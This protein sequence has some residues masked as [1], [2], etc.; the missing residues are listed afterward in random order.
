MYWFVCE[1]RLY[2]GQQWRSCMCKQ[3]YVHGQH[4]LQLAVCTRQHIH[5]SLD[6][7]IGALGWRHCHCC[8]CLK[9]RARNT[10][11]VI[12]DP[13]AGGVNDTS[14]V[15]LCGRYICDSLR[16]Y[17]C[18]LH[19]HFICMLRMHSPIQVAESCHTRHSQQHFTCSPTCLL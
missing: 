16:L 3:Q 4:D 19:L 5:S 11:P 14:A 15:S 6:D 12:I 1:H 9:R 8:K 17:A 2:A 7:V 10:A 13:D 18:G